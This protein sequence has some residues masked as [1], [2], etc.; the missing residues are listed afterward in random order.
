[1]CKCVA[2]PLQQK[3]KK[4]YNHSIKNQLKNPSQNHLEVDWAFESHNLPPTQYWDS[5][6]AGLTYTPDLPQ[7]LP[8]DYWQ[9]KLAQGPEGAV[10]T[11]SSALLPQRNQSL[12]NEPN[13]ELD[14][15]LPMTNHD[16]GYLNSLCCQHY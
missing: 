3:K 2:S 5:L 13:S 1:M 8:V 7:L 16:Q 12:K 6:A 4:L 15:P 14:Q 9:E 11:P 10:H